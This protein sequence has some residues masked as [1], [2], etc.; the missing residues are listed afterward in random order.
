MLG[1][2]SL[3]SRTIGEGEW[4]ETLDGAAPPPH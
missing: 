4:A 1:K 3:E 2:E